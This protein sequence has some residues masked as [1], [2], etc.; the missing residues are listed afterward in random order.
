MELGV[1]GGD[2]LGELLGGE[3]GDFG[4]EAVYF[5]RGGGEGVLF[6]GGADL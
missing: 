3:L 5:Y 2:L 6:A 4:G 1:D